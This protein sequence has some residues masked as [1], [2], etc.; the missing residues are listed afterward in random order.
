[1]LRDC[2]AMECQDGQRHDE[3][4]ISGARLYQVHQISDLATSMLV[5]PPYATIFA[6]LTA[7][8]P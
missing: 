7:S 4:E 1:M 6:M 2:S 3:A 5:L 8:F